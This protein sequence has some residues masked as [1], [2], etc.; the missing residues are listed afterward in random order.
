MQRNKDSCPAAF[1]FLWSC[2]N[3]K[4]YTR[5]SKS[6]PGDKKCNLRWSNWFYMASSPLP[7]SSFT[8]VAYVSCPLFAYQENSSLLVVRHIFV[9]FIWG[10]P[11]YHFIIIFCSASNRRRRRRTWTCIPIDS[12]G[13]YWIHSV[14]FLPSPH[15]IRRRCNLKGI[16]FVFSF[17]IW[18]LWLVNETSREGSG[19]KEI[20]LP[21]F[22]F[23]EAESVPYSMLRRRGWKEDPCY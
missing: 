4:N 23:W 20:H 3:S 16:L 10:P 12:S 8:F 13:C 21:C 1:Y 14:R 15:W 9:T 18:M 11:P 17:D 2:R 22:I 5:E 19:K 6:C 7:S